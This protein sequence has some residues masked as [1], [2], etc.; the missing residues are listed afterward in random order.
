MGPPSPVAGAFTPA[1][2]VGA[3]PGERVERLA[4]EAGG[5]EGDSKGRVEDVVLVGK[6]LAGG[7]FEAA[8][9]GAH[10]G[11]G[12]VGEERHERELGHLG[13]RHLVFDELELHG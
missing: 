9:C 10:H 1:E 12:A 6:D 11:T 4:T 2:D 3:A 5:L 7:Q 13:L 8:A